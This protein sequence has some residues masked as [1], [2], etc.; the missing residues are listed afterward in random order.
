M[1]KKMLKLEKPHEIGLLIYPG[2]QMSAVHGLTDMFHFADR[3]ARE[4]LGA[5]EAVIRLSHLS[6]RDSIEASRVYDTVP[7]AGGSPSFIIMAPSIK[8][9]GDE[10][11]EPSLVDWLREQYAQGT[12]LASVCGG[13]FLMAQTGVLKGRAVTTHYTLVSDLVRRFP[14]ISV[15]PDR[16]FINH[17]DVMTAGGLMSWTDLG[18]HIIERTLGPVAMAETARFMVLDPPGREQVFYSVFAPRLAHGDDA[19]L[20]VQDRL[21]KNGPRDVTVS[22][23]ASWSGLEERTFMRRFIKATGLRP[24][25]YFQRFRIGRAREMLSL[26][27]IPVERVAW[28]VGYDDPASFRKVFLKLTGL[29]PSGYR[30]RFGVG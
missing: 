7:D 6:P 28:A 21:A 26:N 27:R 29:T 4:R 2:V 19:I 11:Y 18:L 9:P 23:M 12:K 17:G 20:K 10:G 13:A 30:K 22:A 5:T 3:L 25:D 24:N 1:R 14:G 8:R 15:D 16:L